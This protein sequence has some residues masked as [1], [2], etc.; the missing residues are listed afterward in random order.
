[1]MLDIEPD[2]TEEE[3]PNLYRI[4]WKWCGE[5]NLLETAIYE[6]MRYNQFQ[7]YPEWNKSYARPFNR[8][9]L[10]I[11]KLLCVPYWKEY[12]TY[13]HMRTLRFKRER[14]YI[15]ES[16]N[17]KSELITSIDPDI[18]N[19][20]TPTEKIA[21]SEL[22]RRGYKNIIKTH[23]NGKP[24]FIC[25]AG[26]FEIKSVSALSFSLSQVAEF[27]P[28]DSILIY[29]HNKLVLEFKWKDR[30]TTKGLTFSKVKRV[31]K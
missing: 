18:P 1:M 11:L 6:E 12:T 4:A 5:V 21:M 15:E 23:G 2:L 26:R 7:L 3:Y 9:E 24:D 20:I 29:D 30:A 8:Q 28:E 27:E 13:C 17:G 19:S 31:S 16:R 14:A 22:K 25:D 10:K